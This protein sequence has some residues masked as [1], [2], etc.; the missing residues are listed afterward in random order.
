MWLHASQL[1]VSN[2]GTFSHNYQLINFNIYCYLKVT[3]MAGKEVPTVEDRENRQALE[4]LPTSLYSGLPS[5][6]RGF[7]TIL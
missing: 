2:M 5:L 7:Q 4:R 1:A 3:V 6:F